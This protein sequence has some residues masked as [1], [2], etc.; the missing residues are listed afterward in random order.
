MIL[1]MN[2]IK[3]P[4]N[5]SPPRMMRAMAQIGISSWI[6]GVVTIGIEHTGDREDRDNPNVMF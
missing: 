4:N 6:V 2:R 1:M 3:I 5:S